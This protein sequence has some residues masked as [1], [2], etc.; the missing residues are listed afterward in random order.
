MV[1]S[2]LLGFFNYYSVHC[3]FSVF[4]SYFVYLG[5]FSVSLA[6]DLSILFTLLRNQFLVLLIFFSNA[7]FNCYFIYFLSDLWASQVTQW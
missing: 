7:L 6:R 2:I 5:L 1:H 4:V 3:Y